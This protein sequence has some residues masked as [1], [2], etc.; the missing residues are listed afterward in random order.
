MVRVQPL[1]PRDGYVFLRGSSMSDG[2]LRAL[3]AEQHP[4]PPQTDAIA[5][6]PGAAV[7]LVGGGMRRGYT[8]SAAK[9]AT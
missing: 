7:P 5:F 8:V 6:R 2:D 9:G 4:G 1:G 3:I